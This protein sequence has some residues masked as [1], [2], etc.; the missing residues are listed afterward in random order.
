MSL[1]FVSSM[2][3]GD[4]RDSMNGDNFEHWMLNQLF[5]NLKEPSV[6]IMDNARYHNVLLEKLPTQS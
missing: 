6:I 3:L 1:I 2:K 5:P 4:Y